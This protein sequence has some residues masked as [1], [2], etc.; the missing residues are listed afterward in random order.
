MLSS[1]EMEMEMESSFV[2]WEFIARSGNG[3]RVRKDQVRL[4]SSRCFRGSNK[5]SPDLTPRHCIG[6]RFQELANG[7][8]RERVEHECTRIR[9]PPCEPLIANIRECLFPA[10]AKEA[11]TINQAGTGLLLRHWSLVSL[12]T[13][14]GLDQQ[15][16]ACPLFPCLWLLPFLVSPFGSCAA[17]FFG[18]ETMGIDL[19]T[20]E[21]EDE[22]PE[23]LAHAAPPP[24]A[25]AVE[26]AFQGTQVCLE[27]W[28]A[29]AG[30]RIWLPKM[31]S[32]VVYLPQGHM[33]HLGDGG[34]GADG[35]GRG[36]I[37]RRDVPP[38]VLC[39]VIDVKLHVCLFSHS[40]LYHSF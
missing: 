22:E 11:G 12:N 15:H 18:W 10:V 29:C 36:G 2:L 21:E 14:L 28:H 20:I 19:N 40:D 8:K 5:C 24:A 37:C 3:G 32:L 6:W 25:A 1:R 34:G 39:R 27:L 13:A 16:P 7:S 4:P 26:D 23:H 30:P 38:H 35:G 17:R 33:E 9:P 31:G